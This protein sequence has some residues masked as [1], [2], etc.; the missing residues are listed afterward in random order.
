MECAADGHKGRRRRDGLKTRERKEREGEEKR[1]KDAGDACWRVCWLARS[2]VPS[3]PK[4]RRNVFIPFPTPLSDREGLSR[5]EWFIPSISGDY[6]IYPEGPPLFLLSLSL[7]S[8]HI[9]DFSD[10]RRR[11]RDSRPIKSSTDTSKFPRS[12]RGFVTRGKKFCKLLT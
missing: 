5:H 10:H 11:S 12:I 6:F 2:K 7:Q 3:D 1:E 4:G 9:A 8:A